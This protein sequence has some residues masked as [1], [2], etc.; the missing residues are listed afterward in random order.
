MDVSYHSWQLS[1]C[2]DLNWQPLTSGVCVAPHGNRPFAMDVDLPQWSVSP[3][4][5]STIFTRLCAQNPGGTFIITISLV[6]R[7]SSVS[8]SDAPH[9]QRQHFRIT[10]EKLHK[11]NTPVQNLHKC[12][13]SNTHNRNSPAH[14]PWCRKHLKCPS[15]IH[16][17]ISWT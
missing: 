3:L 10:I 6:I 1:T 5:L 7:E 8:A 2:P 11:L 14:N 13:E 9:I 16:E 15:R 4:A 17:P 12:R